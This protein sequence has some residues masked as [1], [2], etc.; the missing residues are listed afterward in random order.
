[1]GGHFTRGGSNSKAF[2]T[3]FSVED[4]LKEKP[5]QT[6]VLGKNIVIVRYRL[7]KCFSSRK[8]YLNIGSSF[9]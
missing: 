4:V 3:G 9:K 7:G 5:W 1:M 2:V 8:F 6:K